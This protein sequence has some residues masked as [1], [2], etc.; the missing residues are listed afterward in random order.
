MLSFCVSENKTRVPKNLCTKDIRKAK[1][2]F[3]QT[4]FYYSP[5]VEQIRG[6]IAVEGL[7]DINNGFPCTNWF[8]CKTTRLLGRDEPV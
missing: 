7:S 8:L 6:G 4:K 3:R 5:V 1:T 2:T